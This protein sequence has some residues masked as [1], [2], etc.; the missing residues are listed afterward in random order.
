[1]KPRNFSAAFS[2]ALIAST[3]LCAST[4]RAE[5]PT[6]S[7]TAKPN[8]WGTSTPEQRQVRQNVRQMQRSASTAKSC[9]Q[10]QPPQVVATAKNDG[11]WVE[12]PQGWFY[13]SEI[14]QYENGSTR[15]VCYY[16][17]HK[18]S[19]LT[20]NSYVYKVRY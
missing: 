6:Q 12:I 9:P 14:Q 18:D 11:G 20:A 19:R 13:K 16:G 7:P 4:S 8:V 2:A 5:T 15:L 10:E 1:M 3:L 17:Y